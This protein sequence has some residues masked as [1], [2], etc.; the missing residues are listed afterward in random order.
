MNKLILNSMNSLSLQLAM[1]FVSSQ[2][3]IAGQTYEKYFFKSF[4][5]VPDPNNILLK[6]KEF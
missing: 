4:M 2:A 5:Y 6:H 1:N 3:Y